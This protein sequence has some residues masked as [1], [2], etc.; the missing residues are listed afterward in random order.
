MA[1]SGKFREE[2]LKWFKRENVTNDYGEYK[3]NLLYLGTVRAGLLSQSEQKIFTNDELQFY[4]TK[5]FIVRHYVKIKENDVVEW[6]DK[7]WNV[8]EVLPNKYYNNIE[9]NC[10]VI[11]E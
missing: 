8:D 11:N 10:S 1:N 5:R 2:R 7:K 6:N 3:E 4:Q 9:I